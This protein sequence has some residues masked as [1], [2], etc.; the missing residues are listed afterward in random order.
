MFAVFRLSFLFVF[1]CSFLSYQLTM[2]QSLS[3]GYW[4]A[5]LQLEKTTL[6]FEFEVSKSKE[7]M[8]VY[9]IN[10]AE[11]LVADQV[12]WHGDSVHIKMELFDSE[13]IAKL[14]N[15]QLTGNWVRY[16]L[17]KSYLVPFSASFLGVSKEKSYRFFEKP[18]ATANFSGKWEANFLNEKGEVEEKLVGVF[19]QKNHTITGTFLSVT[20]DYRFLAG[21]VKD[22]TCYLS[23]FDGSHAYVV[24]VSM[25]ADGSLQG[26]FFAGLSGYQRWAATKNDKATL[27]DVNS[28][29]FLKEGYDKIAFS[30]PNLEGKLVSLADEKYKN[31]VVIVQLLGSWCPNCMDETAFLATYFRKNKHKDIAIIGLAFERSAVTEEAKTRVEKLIKRFDIQYEILLAGT[32]DKQKAAEAL[33]MLSAVLAFPTTIYI[34][35]QG[36]VRKIHT[37]FSGPGTGKYYEKFVKDFERLID[38]LLKE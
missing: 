12:I 23:T 14:E 8:Q 6:P 10:G 17:G 5:V 30:F 15:Q 11:K 29:T 25:Q 31:K 22:N 19:E 3:S 26:E 4:R 38:T 34:D 37:G 2:A 24:Q 1:V 13:I 35:K 7:V 36:K 20:G 28:L 16:G 33:P 27:P 18:T 21:E 32:K 9:F